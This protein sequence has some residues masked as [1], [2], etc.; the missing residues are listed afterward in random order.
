LS[1]GAIAQALAAKTGFVSSKAL[2]ETT[3]EG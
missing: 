1:F 2:L 3:A